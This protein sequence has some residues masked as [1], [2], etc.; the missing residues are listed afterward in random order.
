M[1][2]TLCGAGPSQT[3]PKCVMQITPILPSRTLIARSTPTSGF[4]PSSIYFSN[5]CDIQ[6][7]PDSKCSQ[8]QLYSSPSDVTGCTL[9]VVSCFV[10]ISSS[11]T[12]S[13]CCDS[14]TAA[15]CH[16]CAGMYLS[17]KKKAKGKREVTLTQMSNN[18]STT[19]LNNFSNRGYYWCQIVIN[20]RVMLQPSQFLTSHSH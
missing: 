17:K 13:S 3:D 16:H 5:Y 6:S 1:L 4:F 2:A 14:G 7:D 20:N 18:T 19:G 9:G 8:C 10:A 12:G 11:S 15:C